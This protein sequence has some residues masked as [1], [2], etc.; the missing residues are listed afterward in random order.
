MAMYPCNVAV[1]IPGNGGI[2]SFG[3]WLGLRSLWAVDISVG[4]Y[5]IYLGKL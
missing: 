5:D 4:I 2:S 1:T 3:G